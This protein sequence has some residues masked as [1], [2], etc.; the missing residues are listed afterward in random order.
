MKRASDVDNGENISACI[1]VLKNQHGYFGWE[2]QRK[3]C[4]GAQIKSGFFVGIIATSGVISDLNSS[5]E[6]LKAVVSS[7]GDVSQAVRVSSKGTQSI[8]CSGN[9]FLDALVSDKPGNS[10]HDDGG[11]MG[12][13]PKQ[14]RRKGRERSKGPKW[15]K[16]K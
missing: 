16:L 4:H 14:W 5:T 11:K 9:E 15:L 6:I 1:V 2:G 8:A 12:S 10:M 3:R 7:S 13:D